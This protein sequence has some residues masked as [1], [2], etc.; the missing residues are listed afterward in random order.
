[1]KIAL[2]YGN[3]FPSK[4]TKLFTGSKCYHIGWVD[5]ENSKFYDMNLLRRRKV[6]PCYPPERV[7]LVDS[8]VEVT[9]KFLEDQ[10]DIDEQHY[11]IFD[12]LLFI[13]RPVYHFFGTSTRNAGGVI[14]SEMI[15]NDLMANG[16]KSPFVEVPSPGDFE[17]LLVKAEVK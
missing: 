15:E 17:R 16:W 5:E 1:M 7:I 10:L 13:I 8:P 3:N 2:I 11:G 9:S 14:C 4:L 6:W 12:Y